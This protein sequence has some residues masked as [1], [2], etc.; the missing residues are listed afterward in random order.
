MITWP[1]PSQQ[2]S[3][4]NEGRQR[5]LAD[6]SPNANYYLFPIVS[7]PFVGGGGQSSRPSFLYHLSKIH[8]SL[9]SQSVKFYFFLQPWH[10]KPFTLPPDS[11]KKQAPFHSASALF[12]FPEYSLVAHSYPEISRG[13]VVWKI[14]GMPWNGDGGCQVGVQSYPYLTKPI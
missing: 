6:S 9:F 11:T 5:L 7:E 3:H 10:I 1:L 12:H 2:L 8:K 13:L 14:M 4:Q